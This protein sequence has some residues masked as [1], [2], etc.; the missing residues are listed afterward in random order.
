MLFFGFLLLYYYFNL[1]SSI[2]SCLSSRDISF[3]SG[4]SLDLRPVLILEVYSSV[5]LRRVKFQFLIT[6]LAVFFL[7]CKLFKFGLYITA[8]FRYGQCFIR[9]FLVLDFLVF[10]VCKNPKSNHH[11]L[12]LAIFS[13]PQMLQF[14]SVNY[15]YQIWKLY[16]YFEHVRNFEQYLYLSVFS[17][18]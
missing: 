9:R 10:N 5:I 1:S 18:H 16:F 6:F 7:V 8:Y 4:I 2:I 12:F 17:K 11:L 3:R 15:I 13:D 14:L